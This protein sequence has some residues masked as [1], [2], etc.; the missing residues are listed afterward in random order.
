MLHANTPRVVPPGAAVREAVGLV[1]ARSG[2][3]LY[4]DLVV[5]DDEGRCVGVV[6]VHDL[7]TAVHHAQLDTALSLHAL[8]ELPSGRAIEEQLRRR[9]TAPGGV[10]VHWIDVDGFKTIN[11]RL[12]FAAGDALIK[13]IAKSLGSVAA[14]IPGSWLGHIGGDD[15]VLLTVREAAEIAVR[16]LLE[17]L[18]DAQTGPISVSVATLDCGTA[19][20]AEPAEVSRQLAPVKH[21]AKQ[22]RGVS[23][24]VGSAWDRH[25]HLHQVGPAVAM[26]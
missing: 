10:A 17:R 26:R 2:N 5:V 20:I 24:A 8:T 6:R 11:D 16:G 22:V 4:D 15:F 7:L 18:P 3:R 25:I 9:L 13:E 23:W 19:A 21:A 14:V 1:T 12:G